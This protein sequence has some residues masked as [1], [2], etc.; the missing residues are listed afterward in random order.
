MIK[1]S[2]NNHLNEHVKKLM[3]QGNDYLPDGRQVG[4]QFR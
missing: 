3:N 2:K 1:K 4:E